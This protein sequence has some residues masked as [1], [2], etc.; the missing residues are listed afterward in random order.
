MPF[1]KTHRRLTRANHGL[2]L[3]AMAL[4]LVGCA[5]TA[6][7]ERAA[8]PLQTPPAPSKPPT[9]DDQTGA[10]PAKVPATPQDLKR[11]AHRPLDAL[12][13]TPDFWKR[14][15]YPNVPRLT[16]IDPDRVICR[17]PAHRHGL[18][19]HKVR[20][21]DTLFKI[22]RRYYRTGTHWQLIYS[23]NSEIMSS[24]QAVQVGQLLYLPLAPL[25]RADGSRRGPAHRP[26]YYVARAGDSLAT[27]AAFVM[28]SAGDWQRLAR[29][30][31]LDEPT[32]LTAGMR[33]RIPRS[34]AP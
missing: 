25:T 15:T 14:P 28:G 4:W 31:R 10:S 9:Y 32:H 16:P 1:C 18:L 12:T 2:L 13:P 26:D 34:S 7:C 8:V 30:N 27:I 23:S 17:E 21:G 33:L 11:L 6:G 24:P 20:P 3:L 22:S 5:G 29:I 19:V